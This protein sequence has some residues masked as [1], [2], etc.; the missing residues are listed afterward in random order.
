MLLHHLYVFGK[1]NAET[2]EN[3]VGDGVILNKLLKVSP[4][5][6]PSTAVHLQ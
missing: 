5:A 6:H 4:K 2:Y 1:E 3:V